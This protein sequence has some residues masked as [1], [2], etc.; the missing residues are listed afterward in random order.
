MSSLL[1]I[2][3]YLSVTSSIL[4]TLQRIRWY[5]E[6]FRWQSGILQLQRLGTHC[7]PLEMSLDLQLGKTEVPNTRNT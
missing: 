4:P 1:F 5:E 7:S 2:Q 6:S 3:L